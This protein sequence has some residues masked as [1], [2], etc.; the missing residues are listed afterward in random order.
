MQTSVLR[1]GSSSLIRSAALCC[2]AHAVC[3]FACP[4]S[5]C[6]DFEASFL[7]LLE[8]ITNGC[9]I[10]INNTGTSLKYRPGLMV[11][12]HILGLSHACPNS[13]GIGYFLDPLLKLALFSKKALAITLT[14]ITN[15]D[16][17]PSVDVVRTVALQL[18][19]KFGIE[20]PIELKV[21]C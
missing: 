8:K 12:G 3:F 6:A 11:G 14:G 15:D 7:R 21:R 19:K 20:D 17:D 1:C 13:R 2:A 10:S 4:V 16:V 18:V 5:R 9:S